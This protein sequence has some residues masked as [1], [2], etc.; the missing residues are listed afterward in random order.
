[1]N[2][3][4]LLTLVLVCLA[5]SVF[6]VEPPPTNEP[7]E[8]VAAEPGSADPAPTP[9]V[10][11]GVVVV[12][13]VTVDADQR[14][15]S[16]TGWVNQVYGVIELLACGPGGKTHES[17]FVLDVNPVDLQTGLLLLGIKPG[18][19]PTGLGEGA[20]SGPG[21]TLWVDWTADEKPHSRRAEEFVFNEE[22]GSRLEQTP[23]IF[24]GSV[25]E[26]GQFKALAEESLVATYWDPWAI[27]NIPLPC[28]SDDTILI[29][30][31][32]TVP[33]LSTP[34]VMRFVA[35]PAGKEIE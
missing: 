7:P 24:T 15:V 28:G 32:N 17:V 31:T 8:Q 27:V 20:P 10:H 30:D 19:P 13:S 18:V 14:T 35:P 11:D 25:F 12:G 2:L 4:K 26:E 6:S 33:P 1:M 22:S 34:I 3:Q 16:V 23:W 5:T 21:L 9:A 29:V